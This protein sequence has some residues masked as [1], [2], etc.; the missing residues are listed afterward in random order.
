MCPW[1]KVQLVATKA[2]HARGAELRPSVRLE[3]SGGGLGGSRR[4]SERNAS[5]TVESIEATD[6]RSEAT[7]ATS[8]HFGH[9]AASSSVGRAGSKVLE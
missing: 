3:T 5:V 2:S 1:R 6:G 7:E 9:G 8:H 4:V